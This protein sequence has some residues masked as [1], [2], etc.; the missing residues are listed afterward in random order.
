MA[1]I[2][3]I[4]TVYFCLFGLSNS[5]ET[6]NPKPEI[7]NL[8]FIAVDDLRNEFGIYGSIAQSHLDALA[9]EGILFN[10][11]YVQVPP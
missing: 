9:S 6:F 8:P 11:H 10:D 2:F 4:L 1:P 3:K 7:P 5:P